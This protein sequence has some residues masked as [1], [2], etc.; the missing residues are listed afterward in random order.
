VFD[1]WF[2]SVTTDGEVDPESPDWNEIFSGSRYNFSFDEEDNVHLAN[3]RN[4]VTAH[5]KSTVSI[6]NSYRVSTPVQSNTSR[7]SPMSSTPISVAV[8]A[9]QP[10]NTTTFQP[11]I[12][13]NDNLKG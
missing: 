7:A 9:H 10:T 13:E 5:I 4:Y 11:R 3:E 1:D 2:S 12:I 8:P 6:P